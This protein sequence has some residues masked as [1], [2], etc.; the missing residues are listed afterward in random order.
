MKT[1]RDRSGTFLAGDPQRDHDR[2]TPEK[3]RIVTGCKPGVSEL[4][5][6]YL[7]ATGDPQVTG[8]IR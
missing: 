5:L 7:K 2:I 8:R 4:R 3:A 6:V 1:D